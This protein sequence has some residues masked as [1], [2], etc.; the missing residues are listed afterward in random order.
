VSK[1]RPVSHDKQ[2]GKRDIFYHS[3]SPWPHGSPSSIH[4]AKQRRG[5]Q[6]ISGP[7]SPRKSKKVLLQQALP[8]G[9]PGKKQPLSAASRWCP[10]LKPVVFRPLR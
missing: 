3:N 9:T 5:S 2:Q 8:A 10:H 6:G 7:H 1:Q 4:Q